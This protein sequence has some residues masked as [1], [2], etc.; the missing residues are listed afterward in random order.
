MNLLAVVLAVSAAWFDAEVSRSAKWP[1]GTDPV[2]IVGTG[3]WDGRRFVSEGGKTLAYEEA[4]GAGL[5]FDPT[6]PR[7]A[8]DGE[9]TLTTEMT[10]APRIRLVAPKAGK[11]AITVLGEGADAAYYGVVTNTWVKLAGATPVLDTPVKVAVTLKAT[12]GDVLVRYAVDGTTLTAD[13]QEWLK[14]S[15]ADTTVTRLSYQGSGRVASLGGEARGVDVCALTIPETLDG[16]SVAAVRVGG[17]EV[18]PTG[19]RVY[20]IPTNAVVTVAFAAERGSVLSSPTMRF[21]MTQA[22]ELPETGRP[23]P[24]DPTAIAISEFMAAPTNGCDWVELRNATNVDVDVA[25][26]FVTDDYA[27]KLSKWKAIEGDAVVPANGYLVVQVDGDV[28]AWPAGV[29]YAKIGLQFPLNEYRACYKMGGQPIVQ[30]LCDKGHDWKAIEQLIPDMMNCGLLGHP[31]VCPDM[32]GSGSWT[33]FLP[34]AP[35]PYEPEI[36]VR[37]AQIHALAPMMQFSA[38]P[39]RMLKGEAFEAVK[40][41]AWTRMKFA[42][43]IL[44]VAKASAKSGEPMLRAMEYEFPGEGAEKLTDQF[45]LGSKLLVAPQVVKGAKTRTVFI[46]SGTWTADDGSEVTGPKTVEVATPLMRLPYFVKKGSG[47]RE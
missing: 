8:A 37:S 15:A 38:A 29:A 9:V 22:M 24:I 45:M 7:D 40:A 2:E 28:T 36:F 47:I 11:A 23:T 34:A 17:V 31:F 12:D 43:Y 42:D 32:I 4:F 3:T 20:E 13:G 44:S 18:A 5:S 10:F 16:M 27:K 46:P 6:V 14:S 25:G 39:W 1:A 35:H 33:A 21:E 19:E 26:W 41:A 30:R